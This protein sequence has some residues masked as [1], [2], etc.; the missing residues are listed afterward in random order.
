MGHRP[1]SGFCTRNM[2]IIRLLFD[3]LRDGDEFTKRLLLSWAVGQAPVPRR[4]TPMMVLSARGV[5]QGISEPL[6]LRVTDSPEVGACGRIMRCSPTRCPDV[7]AVADFGAV[8][9]RESF[10]G[11]IVPTVAGI[12]TDHLSPGD[13][14]RIEP[15]GQRQNAVPPQLAAQRAVCDRP[16]QQLLPDVLAAAEEGRRQR[17]DGG[18]PAAHRADRSCRRS[19]LSITGGEPTLFKDDFLRLI[20]ACKLRCP[21]PGSTCSRTGG[22]ST[23]TRSRGELARSSTLTMLGIP[24]YSDLDYHHDHVVQARGAFEQTM[25]GLQNL[26]QYARARW[27][28]ESSSI[29]LTWERLPQLAEFIY[30]NL[31][32]ADHV[33]FMGLE[34]MGFA[35][36]N[37]SE[38]WI[39][40]RITRR[41]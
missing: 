15:S 11:S 13:V 1:T 10:P 4:V 2:G 8:L 9:C 17:A 20:A 38:L 30:R 24:L 6:L 26:G 35:I 33:T 28:S 40:P 37:V 12:A 31:T 36:P 5:P 39:D 21:R 23:T 34:M 18:A 27:R 3:L 29:E 25:V 41:A 16:V 14:V 22:C 19:S 7:S 32:F